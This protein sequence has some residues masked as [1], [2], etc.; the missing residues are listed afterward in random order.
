MNKFLYLSVVRR[1]QIMHNLSIEDVQELS[2]EM[3]KQQILEKHTESFSPIWQG[4]N[5]RWYT[6]L[7]DETKKSGRK[8]IAKS[9]EEKLNTQIADYYKM[10]SSR[11]EKI[12]LEAFYPQW[13]K[14]KALHS[15]QFGFLYS[16][17]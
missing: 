11:R 7:P 5:G 10:V 1:H 8:L 15:K 14:Y 16:S 6:Y 2:E 13:L 17:H 12:T 4:K 3:T 9:T